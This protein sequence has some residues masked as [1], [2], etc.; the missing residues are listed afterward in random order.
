MI[1]KTDIECTTE[2]SGILIFGTPNCQAQPKAPAA[3][4]VDMSRC[5]PNITFLFSLV[6]SASP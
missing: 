1:L 2:V 5:D 4:P 6:Y 3:A